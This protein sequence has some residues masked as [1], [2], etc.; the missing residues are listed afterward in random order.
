MIFKNLVF[1][2]ISILHHIL[3][4]NKNV[5]K[6]KRGRGMF[7]PTYLDPPLKKPH[8]KHIL[9]SLTGYEF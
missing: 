4:V 8:T 5:E 9:S 1:I 7:S 3:S 6:E 2:T